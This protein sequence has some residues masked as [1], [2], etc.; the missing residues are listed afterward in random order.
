M[1]ELEQLYQEIHPKVYAFFYVKTSN[2]SVA[3]DLTHDTFYEA[4]KGYQS[5]LGKSTIQTW[6][7]SIANHILKKYYRS[8]KYKQNLEKRLMN[9][10]NNPPLIE[11]VFILKE[12]NEKLIHLIQ[13]LDPLTHEIVSLRLFGELS[14][15]DI[16]EIVGKSENYTRVHFHRTK[17]KLQAEMEGYDE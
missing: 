12:T 7:F 4:I 16:G 10:K 3:E 1:K 13:Q 11:E 14:F 9:E 8:N 6:V 15:K 2:K 5:F 17:L